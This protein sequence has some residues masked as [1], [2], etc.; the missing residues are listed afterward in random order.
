MNLKMT[1]TE[2]TLLKTGAKM[3]KNWFGW[4]IK[5][6]RMTNSNWFWK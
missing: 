6:Y 5:E 4:Y 2:L 3:A 1:K